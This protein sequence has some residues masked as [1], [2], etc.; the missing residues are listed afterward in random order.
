LD[1]DDVL[2]QI[3]YTSLD[4]LGP[5]FLFSTPP[6]QLEAILKWLLT[7]QIP[8]KLDRKNAI[9]ALKTVKLTLLVLKAN[10]ATATPE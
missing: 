4:N 3:L 2:V 10:L 5:C 7:V 1:C 9:R 8:S 6:A